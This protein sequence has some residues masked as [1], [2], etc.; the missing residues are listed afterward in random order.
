[1]YPHVFNQY[2]YIS[3][4]NLLINFHTDVTVQ[5]TDEFLIDFIDRL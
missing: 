3:L 1:M 4:C 5:E 2:L